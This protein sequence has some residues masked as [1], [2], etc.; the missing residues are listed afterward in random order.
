MRRIENLPGPR[1]WPLVG[2]ALQF[3]ASEFHQQLERWCVEYGPYF[4]IHL[5]PRPLL[6]VGEHEAVAT[7][8]RDRP[9]GFRRTSRLENIS[10]EIGL[11]P[12]LFGAEGDMWRRQR[13]MVMA[14]F[15]P[16]HVKHYFPSL[17]RVARAAD[18]A[19]AEAAARA[20]NRSTCRPT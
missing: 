11:K 5:G 7:A 18:R 15:D 13:R 1:P 6:I 2:N 10:R 12:G 3:K 17:A 14:S 4:K 19:L 20:T 9:D 16:A 8:L